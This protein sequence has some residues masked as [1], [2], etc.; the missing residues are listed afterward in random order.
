MLAT[1]CLSTFAFGRKDVIN[2]GVITYLAV[3]DGK[4]AFHCV[5][6]ICVSA[7]ASH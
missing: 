5:L 2:D 3:R 6:G 4:H 7:G 1:V